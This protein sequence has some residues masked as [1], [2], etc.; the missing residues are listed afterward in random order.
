MPSGVS[1]SAGAEHS[2]RN[3]HSPTPPSPAVTVAPDVVRVTAPAGWGDRAALAALRPDLVRAL[4]PPLPPAEQWPDHYRDAYA[5]RVA[6]ASEGGCAD[7]EAVA[8]ADLRVM[9]WRELC[10][11]DALAA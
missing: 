2:P 10:A 5:E 6:V 4:A 9:H 11:A 8:L 3:P 1:P 7:P